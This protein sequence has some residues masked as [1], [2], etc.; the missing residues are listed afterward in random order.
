MNNS[1]EYA[2]PNYHSSQPAPSHY[3]PQVQPYNPN[4]YQ[5]QYAPS[6]QRPRQAADPGIAALL[7]VLGGMFAQT[8]GMGHIYAGNVGTGLLFMFGYWFLCFINIILMFVIIG[9]LTYPLCW[10]MIM[11]ISPIVAANSV[12]RH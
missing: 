12:K 5:Q 10:I 4:E 11:I 3:Q 6:Y 7:E 8:F 9:V 1:S 2:S